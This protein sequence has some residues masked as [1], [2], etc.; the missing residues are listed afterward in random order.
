MGL[1]VKEMGADDWRKTPTGKEQQ[2]VPAAGGTARLM[3]WA[4]LGGPERG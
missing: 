3:S 4:M 1:N 2:Q